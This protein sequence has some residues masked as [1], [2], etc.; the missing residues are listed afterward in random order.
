MGSGK[1]SEQFEITSKTTFNDYVRHKARS[2][3][4]KV[5]LTYIRDFDKGFDEQYTY[6][7]MHLLSNRLGNGL[8]KLGLKQGDGIS[9]IEINSPEYLF[10]LFAAVKLGAYTVMVNIGLK[11]DSLQYIVDHSDSK[12]VIIH[13][14]LLD[15]Y[16]TVRDQLPK[17]RHVIVDT[18]EAPADFELPE[19]AVSLQKVMEA[20]DDDIHTRLNPE[21]MSILI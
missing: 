21:D 13:W 9:L 18:N 3:G 20:P 16:R 2:V 8:V 1:M 5:F 17:V 19:G 4:D 14:T 10:A 7:D 11:G 12:F 15:N 6:R